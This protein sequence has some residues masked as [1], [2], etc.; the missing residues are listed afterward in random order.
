MVMAAAGTHQRRHQ[1]AVGEAA[2]DEGGR[3]W[4]VDNQHLEE[5][6]YRLEQ[7]DHEHETDLHVVRSVDAES[8]WGQDTCSLPLHPARIPHPYP[9]ASIG[10]AHKPKTAPQHHPLP[11][12]HGPHLQPRDGTTPPSEEADEAGADER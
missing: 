2:E 5:H 11:K 1:E 9:S 4:H 12:R 3:P 6:Q 8:P 10:V 7:R